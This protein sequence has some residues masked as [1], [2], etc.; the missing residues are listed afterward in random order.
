MLTTVRHCNG[1]VDAQEAWR[2]TDLL[3]KRDGGRCRNFQGDVVEVA[4]ERG[5]KGTE[6]GPQRMAGILGDRGGSD[7]GVG[8]QDELIGTLPK[9]TR[10]GRRRKPRFLAVDFYCGAGGTTRGLIDAG[11]FVIA[12]LDKQESCRRTY[13]A[14]NGNECGDRSYPE[15]LALDLF[16]ATEEHPTGQRAEAVANL[17]RAIGK[18]RSTYPDVPLMFAI[19]APCQPFTKLSKGELRA[20]RAAERYRERNLLGH[21]CAFVERF[22]PDIVLSENVA[23]IAD[24]RY[25]GI[26]EDFCI[27]LR[28][29]GYAVST[30]SVCT[31]DFGIAQY[32]KRSILGAIREGADRIDIDLSLPVRDPDAR[33]TTVGEAFEGLPPLE[34][35]GRDEKIPNHATRNLSELNRK[36]ISHAIPGGSNSYLQT[37]PEGDLS[38]ACHRRVKERLEVNCFTDVYTRM[39]PDRPSPTITTRCHSITNGRFG[40]PD[41]DQIRGISMREAARLQSFRDEY[42]FYPVH[43]VEPIARMIGNAVPPKLASFYA[44]RLVE[45]VARP[46][47]SG[48]EEEVVR[49]GG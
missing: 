7:S 38:L 48:A 6:E 30:V 24:P 22:E 8:A 11:G 41:V 16:P 45:T 42:V 15:F 46:G 20:E 34:P 44:N 29:M 25:G 18:C 5:H 3:D 31:S 36:R 47:L 10:R 1:A 19:C 17:D 21:T 32:R 27:R 26:W 39:A 2:P 14:N 33:P 35:G 40:H 4:T 13:V 23:G 43:Q 9:R 49:D 12:G 37:T 28:G